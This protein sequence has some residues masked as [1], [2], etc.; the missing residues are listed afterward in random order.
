MMTDQQKRKLLD[1]AEQLAS[2]ARSLARIGDLNGAMDYNLRCMAMLRRAGFD[3]NAYVA[4]ETLK[5]A[6]DLFPGK[7]GL[8]EEQLAHFAREVGHG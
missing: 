8:P 6:A 4:A 5:K 7:A 2:S 1:E 3:P